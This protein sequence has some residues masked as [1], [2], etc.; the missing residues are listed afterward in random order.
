MAQGFD[1]LKLAQFDS[2]Q[3]NKI[4]QRQVED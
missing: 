2:N 4:N 1:S 3:A